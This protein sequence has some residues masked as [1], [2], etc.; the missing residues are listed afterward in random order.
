[1]Y[2]RKLK[3]LGF[4]SPETFDHNDRAQY[5]N[6]VIWLEDQKIRHYR[7][8][9]RTV[10][11]EV[12][13][14]AKWTETFN[15]YLTD[16]SCP[17]DQSNSTA[18]LDW[19]LGLAVRVNYSENPAKY[20]ACKP[21]NKSALSANSSTP[22]ASDN[23]LD[24]LDYNDP[25]MIAGITSIASMLKIPPHQDH[26]QVLKAICVLV[27]ERLSKEAL[28][29][30]S[31]AGADSAK[32]KTSLEDIHLGFGTGDY[33]TDEA[34]KIARL[35]HIRNLRDLQTQINEALVS[36]QNVTAD[37]KTDQRLGKIGR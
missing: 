13:D 18:V 12:D 35:L 1:M 3:A 24:N 33:V 30:A 23:P 22:A 7:I 17:H 28:Q 9:D 6:V 16:V 11:R 19:L 5:Q 14:S 34:L 36:V 15:K 27:K 29:A 4:H 21:A 2:S 37:P 25:A 26:Q 20:R 8:E 32:D 10:L 31:T